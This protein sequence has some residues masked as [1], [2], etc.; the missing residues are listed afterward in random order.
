MGRYKVKVESYKYNS[1]MRQW[2]ALGV[3]VTVLV[4]GGGRMPAQELG[5]VIASKDSI[6]ISAKISGE[7]FNWKQLVV[8]GALIGVGA[9]GVG[10]GVVRDADNAVRDM[11]TDLRGDHYFHADDYVQYLPIAGYIGLGV[12]GVKC[13]H[14]FKERFA[15]GATAYLAMGIMVNAIKYSVREKR[16]D[17]G[18]KNSFPSGH[19]ATAFMGAELLRQEYG[20]WIAVGGYAVATGVAFF[21]LYNDRHWLNDVLAGAGIGILSARIG[22]WMLPVYRRWFKWDKGAV[23]LL[24]TY[25]VE[26]RSVGIGFAMNF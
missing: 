11:M 20:T 14:S 17:T 24:P 13:K 3:L 4:M 6:A 16:P 1:R 12:C 10:E 26:R 7:K 9:L 22:Y 8:P 2:R 18:E 5:T 15:A 25:D 23:A 21:R 19:T